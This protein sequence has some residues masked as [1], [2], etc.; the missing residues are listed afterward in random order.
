MSFIPIEVALAVGGA[1]I[2]TLVAAA[3]CSS[4]KGKR[5]R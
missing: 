1:L 2:V 5:P 3:A 4:L